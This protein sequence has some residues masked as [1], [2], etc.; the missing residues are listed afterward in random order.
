MYLDNIIAFNTGPITLLQCKS[1]LLISS[2][3]GLGLCCVGVSTPLLNALFSIL[4]LS[5][6]FFENFLLC[7]GAVLKNPAYY[8]QN[9][10]FKIKIVLES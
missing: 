3:V 7:F 2:P 8:A 1:P 5:Q 6:L 4:G 10:A 9:Y